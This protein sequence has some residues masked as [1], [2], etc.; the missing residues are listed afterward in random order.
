MRMIPGESRTLPVW[1]RR[2]RVT[3]RKLRRA[4]GSPDEIALGF[5]LAT[6]LSIMPTPGLSILVG[7]ALAAFIRMSK[8]SLALGFAVFNPLVCVFLVYPWALPMGQAVVHAVPALDFE[9]LR[10]F[11]WIAE[12]G[13]ALLIG[14]AIA[15]LLIAAPSYLAIRRLVVV[16]RARRAA[17]DHQRWLA[18]HPDARREVE[19]DGE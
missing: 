2:L 3:T 5:A 18:R 15:G 10:R 12:T 11:Q 14:S 13:T 9:A 17:R 7:F 8:V 1:R 19:L 4:Q 16:H 6:W